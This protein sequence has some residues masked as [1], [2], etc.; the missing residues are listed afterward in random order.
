MMDKI[1][2]IKTTGFAYLL[3]YSPTNSEELVTENALINIADCSAFAHNQDCICNIDDAINYL[4]DRGYKI[5]K[6]TNIQIKTL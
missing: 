3:I 2:K 1:E 6:L 4:K 5:Y